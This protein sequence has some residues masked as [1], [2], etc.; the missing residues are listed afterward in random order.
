M[1]DPDKVIHIYP[2]DEED[3]HIIFLT[4]PAIGDPYSECV[5]TPRLNT[6]NGCL[7]VIHNSYDGREGVEIVNE[8]LNS[9]K[10]Q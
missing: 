10:Q 9:N 5:C 1:I 2:L 4:Y 3:D 7:L 8:I 6:E